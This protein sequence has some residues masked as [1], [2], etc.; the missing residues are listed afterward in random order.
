MLKLDA[1]APGFTLQAQDGTPVS[2]PQLHGRVVVLFFYPKAHTLGCTIE[3]CAFRDAHNF[4]VQSG[5][6]VLGVS[7]D[8]PEENRRFAATHHL[9]FQLL[10]DPGDKLRTR[11][12]VARTLGLIPGRATFLID[13]EGV[14]RHRFVSQFNPKAHPREALRALEALFRKP[15]P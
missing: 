13:R 12:Q 4:F 14:L 3:A 6:V 7:G 1:P 10:S 11:Y 9:P 15:T 2:L 8:P 5:A